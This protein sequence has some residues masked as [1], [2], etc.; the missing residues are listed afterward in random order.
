M[1]VGCLLPPVFSAENVTIVPGSGA[2][3]DDKQEIEYVLLKPSDKTSET[4]R[5][6]ERN[7]Y[8]S[9][10]SETEEIRNNNEENSIMDKLKQLAVVG[11]TRSPDGKLR[12]MLG[13][14]ILEA[15][16]LVPQLLPEQSIELYVSGLYEDQIEL[17]WVE[18]KNTGLPPRTFSIPVDLRPYVRFV[19]NGQIKPKEAEMNKKADESSEAI[20][21]AFP[22]VS[23]PAQKQIGQ[24]STPTQPQQ[25]VGSNNVPA[26][27]AQQSSQPPKQNLIW[28]QA[29]SIM[30]PP[31]TSN[32]QDADHKP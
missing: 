25:T 30:R 9:A 6:E 16:K 11:T 32:D 27:D 20:G 2:T 14:M 3:T 17:Q 29:M 23:D 10:K 21:R 5:A 13:D 18:K 4:L 24:N 26:G 22:K 19:L 1:L 7:P 31:V 28:N 8:V 15:G 12:V